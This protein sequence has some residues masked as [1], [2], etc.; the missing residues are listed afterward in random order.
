MLE[1]IRS[2]Y[3]GPLGCRIKHLFGNREALNGVR[4]VASA[5]IS[6]EQTIQ[7]SLLFSNLDAV[8]PKDFFRI[9]KTQNSCRCAV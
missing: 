2:L 1:S 8:F 7:P 3:S 5:I 9:F 6:H 4:Y